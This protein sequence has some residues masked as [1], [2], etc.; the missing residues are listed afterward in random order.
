MKTLLKIIATSGLLVLGW[1]FVSPQNAHA[2]ACSF[3][4]NTAN[5]LTTA[6]SIAGTVGI[7]NGN[8]T[9]SGASASVTIGVPGTPA[10]LFFTPGNS[11]T[12]TGGGQIVKASGSS[13]VKEYV[14]YTDSDND[15]Y[16]ASLTPTYSTT[17][18]AS[19]YKRRYLMTSIGT[20][21][22]YDAN[23]NAKPGQTAWFTTN[24]GDGSFDYNCDGS[25]TQQ[26]TTTNSCP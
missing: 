26:Y 14:Y 7:D 8:L 9:I 10:T 6:C 4:D 15:G 1:L 19:P 20:A 23:A 13:I 5:T 11:I 3:T 22:C 16:A 18:L 17:A 2:V 21:D 24:R 25:S 12:K